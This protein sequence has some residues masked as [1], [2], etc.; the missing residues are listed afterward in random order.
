MTPE[1]LLA[2]L[3]GPEAPELTCEQCF[4]A[5]DAYI[6]H[7]RTE[8]T[9]AADAGHPGMS[10]HLDGCPACAEDRESLDAYLDTVE[11]H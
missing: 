2:H 4:D 7:S 11:T 10:A 6:E 5:L 3:L 1:T 9:V 8:G